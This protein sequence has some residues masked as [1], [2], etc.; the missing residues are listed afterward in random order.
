MAKTKEV[1]SEEE[2]LPKVG[3][4]RVKLV[5]T[6]CPDGK[7]LLKARARGGQREVEIVEGIFQQI[8]KSSIRRLRRNV[9]KWV[10]KGRL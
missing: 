10:E 2:Y 3:N 5:R 7:I 6:L 4:F 1:T 9:K 8:S